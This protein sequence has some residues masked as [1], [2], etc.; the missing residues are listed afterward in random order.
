MIADDGVG[1][2]NMRPN[3][4]GM[5]V[6]LMTYRARLLGGDLRFEDNAS[7]GPARG[8]RLICSVPKASVSYDS[9]VQSDAP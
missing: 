7:S 9:E 8:T 4:T 5:G 1:F 2:S 6:R 3:E